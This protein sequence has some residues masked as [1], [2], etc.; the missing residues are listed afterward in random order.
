MGERDERRRDGGHDRHERGPRGTEFLDLEITKVLYAEADGLAR[1]A[2]RGLIREAIAQRLRERLGDQLAQIGRIAGDALA[3]DI[4]ANLAIEAVIAN[5]QESRSSI[6]DRV[7]EVMAKRS[8][9]TSAGKKKAS[10]RKT[11][12]RKATKRKA[13]K[14]KRS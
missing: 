6:A 5:R 2:A 8:G 3:D 10:K 11:S 4:E 9:T 7:R 1:D 12:P 14:R 13:S